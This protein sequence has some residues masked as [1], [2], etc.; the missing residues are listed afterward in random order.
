MSR[1]FTELLVIDQLG[2][3]IG[4]AKSVPI[5][6]VNRHFAERGIREVVQVHLLTGVGMWT[7]ED[8]EGQQRQD[9]PFDSRVC[10]G[11]FQ[12]AKLSVR[13]T[14]DARIPRVR[15]NGTIRWIFEGGAHILEGIRCDP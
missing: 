7:D 12:A 14:F 8:E 1:V 11:T 6:I 10:R 4:V 9:H 2:G 15:W 13:L 5:L 3:G